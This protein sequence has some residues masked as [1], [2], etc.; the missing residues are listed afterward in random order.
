ML[1]IRALFVTCRTSLTSGH[2]SNL[3]SGVGP[4]VGDVVGDAARCCRFLSATAYQMHLPSH[5]ERTRQEPAHRFGRPLDASGAT[6]L[7]SSEHRGR[8]RGGVG[9]GTWL[10]EV[11]G[12]RHCS[13]G[14]AGGEACTSGG[15]GGGGRCSSGNAVV[16]DGAVSP[17]FQLDPPNGRV[18][19]P[20]ERQHFSLLDC[21]VKSKIEDVSN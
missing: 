20:E 4:L 12:C 15:G 6:K 13:V 19:V 21:I 18:L 14:G 16:V 1:V 7:D 10:G 11:G 17:S 5:N 9:G 3:T 8:V 2:F